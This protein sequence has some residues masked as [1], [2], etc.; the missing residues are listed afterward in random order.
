[1]KVIESTG[2]VPVEA[3]RRLSTKSAGEIFGLTPEAAIAAVTNGDVKL[4]PVP[5]GVE[6]FDYPAF[7]DDIVPEEVPG[8]SGDVTTVDIPDDWETIHHLKLI[9]LAEKITGEKLEATEGKKV[10]EIAREIILEEL[11]KRKEIT[12]A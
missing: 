8:A 1:M 3:I 5:D 12:N 10:T 4:H 9:L 11:E 2:L 6:T 7:F